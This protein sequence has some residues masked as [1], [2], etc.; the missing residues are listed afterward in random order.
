MTD[1]SSPGDWRLPTKEEWEA[2]VA[3][4]VAL[5]CTGPALTNTPGTACYDVG[6][7][8]FLNVQS[9][10]YHW[11]STTYDQGPLQGWSIDMNDGGVKL[12]T[13]SNSTNLVWPV[14]DP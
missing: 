4:A 2:T 5:G 8:T 6:P 12:V 1:G 10:Y 9:L 13:R 11:S 3:K 7:P 14:R